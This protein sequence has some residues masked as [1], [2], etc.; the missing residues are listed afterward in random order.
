MLRRQP[1]R[2]GLIEIRTT[3]HDSRHRVP[4]SWAAQKKPD[5]PVKVELQMSAY[6][7]GRGGYSP[8]NAAR[9]RDGRGNAHAN[10]VIFATPRISRAR[11]TISPKASNS[12]NRD[13]GTKIVPLANCPQE[14]SPREYI[15]RLFSWQATGR[16]P[17]HKGTTTRSQKGPVRMDRGQFCER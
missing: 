2:N 10:L 6:G 3:D 17:I 8:A 9:S 13:L 1:G 4:P 5:C 11:R 14:R 12:G 16:N 7:A 15:L